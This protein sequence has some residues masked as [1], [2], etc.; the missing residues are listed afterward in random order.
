MNAARL[1]CDMLLIIQHTISAYHKGW[2]TCPKNESTS[3]SLRDKRDRWKND[4]T[5][6]R[7]AYVKVLPSYARND[8]DDKYSCEN[9][10]LHQQLREGAGVYARMQAPG[11]SH[12]LTHRTSAG[13]CELASR[14]H[15]RDILHARPV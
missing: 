2:D 7:T 14:E 13:T 6:R 10:A 8:D 4:V 15:R 1:L 5:V 3:M 12:D 11:L 9:C